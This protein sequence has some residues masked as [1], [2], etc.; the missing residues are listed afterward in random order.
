VTSASLR[1][2]VGVRAKKLDEIEAA[3]SA[4]GGSAPGRRW[5]TEQVNHA[6]AMLLSSQFQGFCRDLHS[7][8]VD[9]LVRAVT[10]STLQLVIQADLLRGRKLDLGNPTPSSLGA[11]FNR[12]GVGFWAEVRTVDARNGYRQQRLEELARWRNAI[13][14]QD[15]DPNELVPKRLQL[16]TV[17]RWRSI[18]GALAVSFDRVMKSYISA[19]TGSQPW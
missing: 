2:W 18:C 5:A 1:S 10:P 9:C 12:L 14:H 11:D 7:E 15:F 17:R 8:C 4:V 3:H 16:S 13:A 19:A 6:Y